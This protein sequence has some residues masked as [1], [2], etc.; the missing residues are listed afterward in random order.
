MNGSGR[1]RP[2]SREKF[3]ESDVQ[4]RERHPLIS[5]AAGRSR[6]GSILIVVLMVALGLVAI[7][8][9]F[10]NS[11]VLEYRAADNAEASAEAAQA[12]EGARRYLMYLLKNWQ[13][14]GELPEVGTY[15][16][17]YV[18]V[19]DDAM[20][21]L[22]GRDPNESAASDYPTFGLV[23][24]ASKIN[25]NTATT[26]MLEMLPNMTPDLAAA[27]IDW[28]D[29]DEDVTEYG[30][31]SDTYLKLQPPY[32][33]KNAPFESPE[34]LRWIYDMDYLMLYGE[35]ANRNGILDPN[36]N[37]GMESPPDDNKDGVLDPGL[38]DYV[39][40]W[41]AQ[42]N[43]Q[44]DG[45]AKIPIGPAMASSSS[46]SSGSGSGS[47]SGQGGSNSG[48]SSNN[49]QSTESQAL[50]QLLTDKL[51]QARAQEI[52]QNVQPNSVKS[53]LEYYIKSKMSTSE[54]SQIEDALTVSTE[55]QTVKGLIN[56]NTAPAAVLVC[57][58]GIG[59]ENVSAIVGYRMGKA[60]DVL[61]SISWVAEALDQESAIAAGPYITTKSYQFTADVVALGRKGR[62]MQ[63]DQYVI[64]MSTGTPKVVYRR[65]LNRMGWPLGVVIRQ[66]IQQ[67]MQNPDQ[68]PR[69]GFGSGGGFGQTRR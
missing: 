5:G 43:T 38:L 33:A 15:S 68:S 57:I 69:R 28:R 11:M 16:T 25:L 18:P 67:D 65:N 48:G 45:T 44:S 30:A 29:E 54:F 55:T 20:F 6:R 10:A 63:R 59:E 58:P 12:S 32:Q 7:A 13:Y 24:E 1:G 52:N 14:P 36:E 39:T 3:G 31:E 64:D 21:W 22:L 23:D 47:G 62:G 61:A 49:Q 34:E 17:E 27:I 50:T 26:A 53:V 66:D 51:G 9:Y 41:S 42:P 4:Q 60:A 40:V 37:D 46:S 19:G 56:I 2:R 8:L 35:D